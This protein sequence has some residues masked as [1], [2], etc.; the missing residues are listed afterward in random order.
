MLISS[1]VRIAGGRLR[2]AENNMIR[3]SFNLVI[4]DLLRD[5]RSNDF[6]KSTT[7]YI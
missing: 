5:Q 2:S 7:I 4:H 3:S 1:I 6:S